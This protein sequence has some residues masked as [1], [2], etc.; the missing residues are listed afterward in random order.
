ML[1]EAACDLFLEQGYDG[2]S[3][4]EIARRAGIARSSFFN[5]AASKAELLWGP[6]D[7]RIAAAG[8]ALDAGESV[9]DALRRIGE[10]A[11][12]DALALAF[13]NAE[14]MRIEEHLEAEAALRASRVARVVAR[15]LR[16]DGRD[17]L[18]ADVHA[19]A[20]GAAV[21]AALR[22]WSGAGA[23]ATSLAA[24]VD[25]ALDIAATR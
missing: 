12:P 15:G 3:V 2:T 24:H 1:A 9:R 18:E 19:G 23:G 22:A 14:A 20:Y 10:G 7:D 8:D 11:A 6:L 25:R 4:S 13:A 17:A 5:Y 21:V 16:R